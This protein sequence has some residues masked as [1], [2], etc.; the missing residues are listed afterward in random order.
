MQIHAYT[1]VYSELYILPVLVIT[2]RGCVPGKFVGSDAV[3]HFSNTFQS[4][5]SLIIVL[6]SALPP[7]PSFHGHYMQLLCMH[8]SH[9]YSYISSL[10]AC[11]NIIKCV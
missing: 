6:M 7:Q 11:V 4:N 1:H 10:Q 2:I 8:F 9:G 5:F 3:A